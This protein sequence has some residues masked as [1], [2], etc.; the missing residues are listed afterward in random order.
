MRKVGKTKGRAAYF[1][2]CERE[3]I[4]INTINWAGLERGL[5]LR[6]GGGPWTSDW[7]KAIS[8]FLRAMSD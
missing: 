5:D 3:M 2:A 6:S 4:T 8:T 7:G 1:L